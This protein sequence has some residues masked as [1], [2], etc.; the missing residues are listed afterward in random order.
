MDVCERCKGEKGRLCKC[1][2]MDVSLLVVSLYVAVHF[3]VCVSK[4]GWRW[5][6][7]WEW[8]KLEKDISS[9]KLEF[10]FADAIYWLFPKAEVFTVCLLCKILFY[11]PY[12]QC[13]WQ[14]T[15]DH[16]SSLL[17]Y[18]LTG[19]DILYCMLSW[20]VRLVPQLLKQFLQLLSGLLYLYELKW[21]WQLAIRA[22]KCF[23]FIF[24]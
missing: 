13:W 20:F 5:K 8:A 6:R 16:C 15:C 21:Q 1:M 18:F 3:L 24:N 12:S 9:S 10:I 14:C 7:W 23:Y 11:E 17:I 2:G 22:A 4:S 19:F